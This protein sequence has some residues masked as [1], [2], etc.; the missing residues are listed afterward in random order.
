RPICF[1]PKGIGPPGRREALPMEQLISALEARPA[2]RQ[3]FYRRAYQRLAVGWQDSLARYCQLIDTCV[4]P[5]T[6][7]LDIG[8]GH[9][10][11]LERVFART[12]YTYGIDPDGEALRKN[13]TINYRTVGTAEHLPFA[14][15]SFD[16]IVASWVFEHLEQPEQVC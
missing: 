3:E 8:C 1:V 14:D 4:Q 5:D 2:N 10:D 12:P 15:H 13:T 11:F 7:V 16:L 6:A 9:A